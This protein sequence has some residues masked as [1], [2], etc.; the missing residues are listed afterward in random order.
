MNEFLMVFRNA[1]MGDF[2]PTP[3][4]TQAVDK[5]W[6]DWIGNLAAQG[7]YAGGTHPAMEGKVIDASHVI[8]DGPYAEIKE[9]LMGTVIIKTDSMDAAVE[10][11]KGS[12]ILLVGG[13]VEIRPVIVHSM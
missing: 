12:P 13:T 6:A 3:E 5:Q 10:I 7:L 4:Q 9:I 2:K 8:T 1:G 11:A